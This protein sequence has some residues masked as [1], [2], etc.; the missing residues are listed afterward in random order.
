MIYTQKLA[1]LRASLFWAHSRKLVLTALLYNAT[2]KPKMA[3]T[4]APDAI[5][6]R[7]FCYTSIWPLQ[8]AL[9]CTQSLLPW[10]PPAFKLV[11][12]RCCA[13]DYGGLPYSDLETMSQVILSVY[14]QLLAIRT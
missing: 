9:T 11:V 1:R 6:V 12:S 7:V 8:G 4:K 13:C 14:D 5:V 10:T 2:V 3:P